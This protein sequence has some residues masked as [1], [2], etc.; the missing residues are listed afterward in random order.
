MSLSLY[1]ILSLIIYHSLSVLFNQ[2]NYREISMS[3]MIQC[4]NNPCLLRSS[5]ILRLTT[6]PFE[7]SNSSYSKRRSQ[8]IVT[9]PITNLCRRLPLFYSFNTFKFLPYYK[10]HTTIPYIRLFCDNKF[11]QIAYLK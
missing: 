7:S 6:F 5:Y 10:A 11:L 9:T 3:N 8:G 1:L 4:Y 2:N